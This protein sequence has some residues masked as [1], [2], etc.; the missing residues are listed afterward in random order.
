MK[1]SINLKFTFGDSIKNVKKYIEWFD[2]A[3]RTIKT[4]LKKLQKENL[5]QVVHQVAKERFTARNIRQDTERMRSIMRSF[6]ATV[7]TT[8]NNT[9]ISIGH[10]YFAGKD[11]TFYYISSSKKH[12]IKG[13]AI[14][15]MLD[16]GRKVYKI[17]RKFKYGKILVWRYGEDSKPIFYKLGPSGRGPI[18]A[19]YAGMQN[20]GA[21]RAGG[22]TQVLQR[23]KRELL[24]Y[25]E[26]VQAQ[27]KSAVKKR[28]DSIK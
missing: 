23:I 7:K 12:E 24:N 21:G 5:L 14:L 2:F 13:S 6:Y 16:L 15:K 18:V 10:N 20:K 17:P 8:D 26:L 28:L 3:K 22:G 1:K 27:L 19:K 9:E 25:T 4:Q 11:K